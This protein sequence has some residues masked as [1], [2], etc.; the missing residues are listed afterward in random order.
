MATASVV[1]SLLGWVF[2]LATLCLNFVVLPLLS[3][4]TLGMAG[5]L[6]LCMI[7]AGCLSPIGWLIGVVTGHVAL[8]QVSHTGEAGRGSA[9]TG[10]IA[11]WIG[12]GLTLL[13]ILAV[14]AMLA[15]GVSIPFLQGVV[16][17][18]RGQGR[19]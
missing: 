6:Y 7:P 14:V 3:V 5:L 17:G 13:T 11:G 9:L 16:E 12:L 8:G 15:L 19:Y 10:A 18:I 1:A 4:A 2:F